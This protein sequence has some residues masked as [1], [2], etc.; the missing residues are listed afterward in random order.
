MNVIIFISGFIFLSSSLFIIFIAMRRSAFGG[1]VLLSEYFY[2]IGLGV[3]PIFLGAG[4][5]NA[6]EQ[7]INYKSLNGDFSAG[8]FFHIFLYCAGMILGYFFLRKTKKSLSLKVIRYAEAK[9]ID[10]LKWFHIISIFSILVSLI[11][12]T[13]MGW[14]VALLNAS[15]VRSGDISNLGGAEQYLFLKRIALIGVLSVVFLPFIIS[16]SNKLFLNLLILIVTCILI[17][18]QS[19]SRAIILDM[20]GVYL[21]LMFMIKGFNWK[22]LT[23]VGPLFFFFIFI[24]M[25]GKEA[26]TVLSFNYFEGENYELVSNSKS[27]D[28]SYFMKHFGHLLYSIDSGIKSFFTNGPQIGLDI[29][30]APLGFVPSSVFKGLELEYLSYIFVD[31]D[32]KMSCINTRKIL[33]SYGQCT[34]P[35]YYTGLSAYILPFFSAFIFAFVRFFIYSFIEISWINLKN[36]PELIWFPYFIF[37]ICSQIMWVI[38]VTIAYAFFILVVFLLIITM[39]K[40]FKRP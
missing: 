35:P 27:I 15:L 5:I 20:I 4:L 26:V 40:L 21:V 32:Y 17:Y 34:L 6:P 28:L 22:F 33:N 11:Y 10:N 19:V 13:L 31:D 7:F 14:D 16:T 18:M 23:I 9:N 8:I 39:T 25:F 36:N 1:L 12:F 29:L 37:F 2:V 30:L 24:F 3:F 38:P